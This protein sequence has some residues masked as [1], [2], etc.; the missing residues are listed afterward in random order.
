MNILI[1]GGTGLIGSALTSKL[2]GDG[3]QVTILTRNP[4]KRKEALTPGVSM[5][6]WDGRSTDGW[7]HLVEETDAVI[8]LAGK[9]IAGES[10][11]AIFLRRWTEEGKRRIR[12]TR[13]DAGHALT[14]AIRSARKKPDVFIQSSAVGYYGPRGSEEIPESAQGGSDEMAE[15]C[16]DW[17]A[18]TQEVE[19]MGV[20]RAVIRTSLVFAPV[21]GI[22]PV[23]LLPFRLFI[24]GRLGTG[25][26]MVSWI[27]IQDMV[28]AITFLLGNPVARG[29]FNMS[30][31]NPVSNA[32]FGRIA[33]R[34]L[35][36]PYWF[37]VPGFA[38]KLLLGEKGT[39]VLDGQ[40]TIPQRLLEA[41]FRFRFAELEAALKDLLQV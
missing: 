16:K 2:L 40:G 39:L 31:P 21:G 33:G 32:E 28:D 8:N 22:L 14:A 11:P 7:S 6:R 30:S 15:I 13:V 24:G 4:E 38:L 20:R 19:Q 36:R 27:H 5:V 9:S 23:M 3:H 17:E 25:R 37:P 29:V 18:S 41:G 12:Q 1:A 34:V 35:R 10:L 26:Q